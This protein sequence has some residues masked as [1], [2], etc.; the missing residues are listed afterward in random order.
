MIEIPA[1]DLRKLDRATDQLID[2][3]PLMAAIAAYVRDAT[4]Q[5]FRDQ[6]GPDGQ[7][8]KL[9]RRAQMQGGATLVDRGLLRDSYTDRSSADEAEVGTNDIR[10]A[11]HHFGGV[12]RAK[13]G[14]A[15]HFGL[16]GGGF[17]TVSQV[18]MPARPALGV[19]DDDRIEI[20]AL[21]QDFVD[22]AAG[23]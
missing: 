14:G 20:T 18:V 12:I 19:N 13:A 21:V 1:A 8:W 17:A 6:R 3:R 4:R 10:A 15:L 5:R 2:T 16:S 22:R 11:I 7:P 23:R 9:S